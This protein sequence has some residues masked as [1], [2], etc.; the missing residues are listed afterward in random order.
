MSYFSFFYIG[1]DALPHLPM[2]PGYHFSRKNTAAESFSILLHP[3]PKRC[4]APYCI[5]F[6]FFYF[7]DFSFYIYPFLSLFSYFSFLYISCCQYFYTFFCFCERGS[8]GVWPTGETWARQR[9]VWPANCVHGVGS[10][11]I[12]AVQGRCSCTPQCAPRNVVAALNLPAKLC[13]V[14]FS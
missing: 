5:S 9:G 7:S 3:Q 11:R 1:S 14:F 4:I 12:G 8:G 2:P 10:G 6:I 13:F